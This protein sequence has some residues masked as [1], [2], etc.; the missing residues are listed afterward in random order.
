M[1]FMYWKLPRITNCMTLVGGFMHFEAVKREEKG[2]NFPFNV[3]PRW[4]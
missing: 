3:P 1:N 4:L 2:Q